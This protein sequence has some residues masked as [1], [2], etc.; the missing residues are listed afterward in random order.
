MIPIDRDAGR[1]RRVGRIIVFSLTSALN[2]TLLA[3]TTIMLLLPNPK[4]LMLGYLLGAMITSITLG[5]VIVFT[6]QGTETTKTTQNTLSPAA[7]LV[8]G[9][10][11]LAIAIVLG[12]GRDQPVRE[13]RERHRRA[14]KEPP[15][16]QRVLSKGTPRATFAL[17]AVLTLPGASY[18]A[19]LHRLSE[20]KYSTAATVLTV[21]G[22]NLVML[23]M[24]EAPLICFAVAPDWT[25]GAIERAKAWV[26]RRWRHVAVYGFSIIGIL[27][28][29]K[30]V[31]GLLK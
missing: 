16:W 1:F 25:P 27:L 14:D 31:V 30:G 3:A 29:I 21:I 26:A 17:G 2:P 6:L 28:L 5:L 7:D 9:A 12:T 23:V 11:A 18:L 15:R 10:I 24:L 19:G 4:R 8:L 20:L 22:F 13:R